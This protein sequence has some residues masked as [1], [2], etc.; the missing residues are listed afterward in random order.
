MRRIIINENM[1]DVIDKSIKREQ[2]ITFYAF[3]SNVKA[4]IGN[5][6]KEPLNAEITPFFKELGIRRS[7]LINMLIERGVLIKENKISNENGVDKFNISYKVPRKNFEKN[8]KKIYIKLFEKNLP[9]VEPKLNEDGEGGATSA[10]A[11]NASAPI[12]PIGNVQRR[13][14]YITQ[15]QAERLEEA[16]TTSSVGNYQYDVPF[17]FKGKNGKKDEAYIHRKPGGISMERKK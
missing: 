2:N 14:I 1:L 10:G 6:L 13:R 17:I 16:T 3:L 15:E 8:I 4:F 9:K 11:C 7:E 5:L 12:S